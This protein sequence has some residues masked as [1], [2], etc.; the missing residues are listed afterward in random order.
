MVTE[1]M[2]V[3]KSFDIAEWNNL[4]KKK[5]PKVLYSSM[6]STVRMNEE[7]ERILSK[8]VNKKRTFYSSHVAKNC[9]NVW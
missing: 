3:A 2:D 7:A 5:M 1:F 4:A 9:T 8:P 6:S